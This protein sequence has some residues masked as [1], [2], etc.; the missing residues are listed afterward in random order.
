M[1]INNR[2]D[3]KNLREKAL[4]SKAVS[5]NNIRLLVGL[6]TCGTAAGA[7]LVWN[8]L[9]RIIKEE[10]LSGIEMVKVGCVGY[11]Y[12]EPTVEVVYPDGD[13]VLLGNIKAPDAGKVIEF[14]VKKRSQDDVNIIKTDIAAGI[15]SNG[16]IK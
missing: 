1:K 6:G 9:D 3:L 16:G 14:H 15:F 5:E 13:S 2:D 11:C 7:D 4:S 10:K 12:A 8:E